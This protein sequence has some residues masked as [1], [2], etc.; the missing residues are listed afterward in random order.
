M[1]EGISKEQLSV[2]ISFFSPISAEAHDAQQRRRV[3]RGKKEKE[4]PILTLK[5][6]FSARFFSALM[7]L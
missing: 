3:R 2:H 6:S 1:T 7:K 5:K 4:C